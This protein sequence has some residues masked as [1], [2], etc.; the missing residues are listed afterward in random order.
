MIRLFKRRAFMTVVLLIFLSFY[1]FLYPLEAGKCEDEF[2]NCVGAATSFIDDPY[3]VFLW[4]SFCAI[5]YAWCML[6]YE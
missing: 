5:G 2:F 4:G 6:Y 3:G 1:L